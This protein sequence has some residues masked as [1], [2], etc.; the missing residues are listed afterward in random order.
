MKYRQCNQ[1][2]DVW[3]AFNFFYVAVMYHIYHIWK[4]KNKTIQDSGY[5]L[6]GEYY[7]TIMYF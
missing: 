5:V 2:D 1:E 4:T 7:Q 6:Q 3:Q